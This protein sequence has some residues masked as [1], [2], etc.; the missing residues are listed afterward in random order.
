LASQ[1]TEWQQEVGEVGDDQV[2][3]RR[4][5]AAAQAPEVCRGR[6]TPSHR[7]DERGRTL[8]GPALVRRSR[9]GRRWGA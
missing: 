4:L 6:S 5:D 3:V 9:S 1:G 2:E 7:I 8:E